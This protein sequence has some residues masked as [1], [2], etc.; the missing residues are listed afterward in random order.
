MFKTTNVQNQT[1]A[2]STGSGKEWLSATGS[3]PIPM[4]ND[5]LFRA[6]LQNN[7]YVL[8]G[9]I[10]ALLHLSYEEV[11]S[12]AIINPII[13]GEA[14]DEKTFFLD[15]FVSLNNHSRINLELQVINEQNWTER[16]LSYLCRAFDNLNSGENYSVVRP[17]IQIGLLDFTLFPQYPEFY[18]TYQFMNIKNYMVYSDKMRLSVLNL[19]CK[20]LATREDKK[21][22]LNL[23]ASFFK[24]T[25][26]EELKMLAKQ[27]KF[28]NE[29]SE[30][31]YQLTQEEQVRLQCEARE[32]YYR[33]QRTIQY[34]L[35]KQKDTIESQNTT[36]EN[37]NATI[38]KQNITIKNQN[39]T[40]QQLTDKTT[41]QENKIT[42]QEEKI[43]FLQ[44]EIASLKQLLSDAGIM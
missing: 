44:E 43:T 2:A 17:A 19:T 42:S 21:C 22:H 3:L 7:N 41:S 27:D 29:A 18:A 39:T 20:D 40:I 36:I 34:N 8:K 37:Q 30:T 4:T 16:S 1:S 12:V 38:E 28:I 11:N 35:D 31:I 13:L 15:I 6:L 25:T 14:I 24:S 26:W 33:R 10:C 32:D 5:Y 9:L 23:W